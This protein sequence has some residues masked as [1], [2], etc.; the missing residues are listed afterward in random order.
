VINNAFHAWGHQFLYDAETLEIDL[1][2]AGFNEVTRESYNESRHPHLR[3]IEKH[4][5]NARSEEM[6]ML[7]TF[8]LEAS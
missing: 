4:G 6:A 3:Q 7:E 8:I 1:R 5:V 2:A